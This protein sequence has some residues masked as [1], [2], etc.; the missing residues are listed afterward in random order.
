VKSGG[1]QVRDVRDLVGT[2]EREKAELG[3]LITLE[4]PSNPM[5]REAVD[6]GFYKSPH[7]KDQVPRIQI[8]TIEELLAGKGIEY[9]RLVDVTFKPAPKA[10]AA[11]AE[12]L[13]LSLGGPE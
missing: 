4:E 6:A 10:K 2:I 1:V 7:F 12:N 11:L 13:T 8:R 3:V 9:P 5:L